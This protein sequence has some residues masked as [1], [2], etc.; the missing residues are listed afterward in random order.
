[1]WGYAKSA[2]HK[3][4]NARILPFC[5]GEEVG[6][7]FLPCTMGNRSNT[8]ISI[9]M[10]KKRFVFFRVSTTIERANHNGE[11]KGEEL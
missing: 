9:G 10:K 2:F 5:L 6:V 7:C 8:N 11:Q 3:E 4:E 1:M